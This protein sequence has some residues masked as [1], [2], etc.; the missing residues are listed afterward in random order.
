VKRVLNS[1]IEEII[2]DKIAVADN[3]YASKFSKEEDF[4]N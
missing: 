3:F 2:I 4:R 1:V